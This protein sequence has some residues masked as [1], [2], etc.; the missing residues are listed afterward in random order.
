MSTVRFLATEK[1]YRITYRDVSELM[2]FLSCQHFKI[3]VEISSFRIG[4]MSL[5]KDTN[6]IAYVATTILLSNLGGL[7]VDS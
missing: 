4:T 1:V 6:H 7:H 3:K 2:Y 5:R